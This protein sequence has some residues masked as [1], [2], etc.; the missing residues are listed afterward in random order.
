MR[1]YSNSSSARS[2]RKPTASTRRAWLRSPCG[3]YAAGETIAGAGGATVLAADCCF[4]PKIFIGIRGVM[5]DGKAHEARLR[6]TLVCGAGNMPDGNTLADACKPC[7]AGTEK[8][9]GQKIARRA[10]PARPP[11]TRQ[12]GRSRCK[13][14]T[15]QRQRG[16]IA[17]SRVFLGGSSPALA[18]SNASGASPTVPARLWQLRMPEMP[19][20]RWPTARRW[21]C[22]SATARR[23]PYRTPT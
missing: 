4:E 2:S 16:R 20:A 8:P 19:R 10:P 13:P 1:E 3:L 7:P 18:R 5:T 23:A 6:P 22:R 12:R 9:L 17:A 15:Y 21:C 14:G 11:R